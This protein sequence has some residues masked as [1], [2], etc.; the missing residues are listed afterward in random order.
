MSFA[1][2]LCKRLAAKRDNFGSFLLVLMN[3]WSLDLDFIYGCFR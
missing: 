2:E 3:S 1:T